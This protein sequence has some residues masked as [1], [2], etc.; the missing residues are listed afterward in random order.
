MH[1]SSS[2][3][4]SSNPHK[5]PHAAV[6]R[7]A[8]DYEN[9]GRLVRVHLGLT[10]TDDISPVL[11]KVITDYTQART[12][13][14]KHFPITND[15]TI[16]NFVR[17]LA[18][19]HAACTDALKRTDRDAENTKLVRTQNVI[20]E[21]LVER[22]AE[23][24]AERDRVIDTQRA[25]MDD[26]AAKIDTLTR[27]LKRQTADLKRATGEV[28][29]LGT[30][31]SNQ[32]DRIAELET[33]LSHPPA[34]EALDISD[35]I[36]KAKS[37]IVAR[38][39]EMH[40]ALLDMHPHA[41]KD[42]GLNEII[43]QQS[44]NLDDARRALADSAKITTAAADAVAAE[45]ADCIAA[46]SLFTPPSDGHAV[47][48]PAAPDVFSIALHLPP[49]MAALRDPILSLRNLKKAA[50]AS[51]ERRSPPCVSAPP[52][53]KRA[54][55]DGPSATSAPETGTL[56]ESEP[57]RSP[58]EWVAPL[59]EPGPSEAWTTFRCT[60]SE[61]EMLQLFGI[62][63]EDHDVQV[64]NIIEKL[65]NGCFKLGVLSHK[66][67]GSGVVLRMKVMQ[68]C[69]TR[70]KDVLLTD[71]VD[72]PRYPKERIIRDPLVCR[73]LVEKRVKIPAEYV[74]KPLKLSA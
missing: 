53:R 72:N 57:P 4:W 15:D 29:E 51:L 54:H 24:V 42:P 41:T 61:L 6:Q 19:N 58:G 60:T 59:L 16:N 39:E 14:Q 8:R 30:A 31:V 73:Y 10:P 71:L 20:L 52:A 2:L 66:N 67:Q 18:D 44:A 68:N 3:C 38:Q 56:R 25:Q 34:Q 17:T 55:R 26:M 28:T 21:Q 62:P 5:H 27:Q 13:I 40:R 64:K 49:S 35:L 23:Q 50:M 65:M 12:A 48:Q 74:L 63:C 7:Y 22:R 46:I 43:K 33:I 32:Q 70:V 36:E 69:K 1:D 9:I 45:I 37:E 11:A 47:A